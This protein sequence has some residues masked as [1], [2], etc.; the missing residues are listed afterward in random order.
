MRPS[1]PDAK[2]RVSPAKT[3]DPYSHPDALRRF[4]RGKYRRT[5]KQAL[6]SPWEKWTV[7]LHPSQRQVVERVFT[8]PARVAGSAGTGKTVVAL[9]RAAS[10][11]ASR[12]ERARPAHDFSEPLARA[13]ERKASFPDRR[14]AA[15]VPA[16]TSPRFLGW[17]ASFSAR[18]RPQAPRRVARTGEQRARQSGRAGGRRQGDTCGVHP[19]GMDAM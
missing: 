9:H 11:R 16:L 12:P 19:F 14:E 10:A 17:R 1:G 13:L 2:A 15:V 7:F 6:D 3:A 4:R 18:F 5:A 8:G